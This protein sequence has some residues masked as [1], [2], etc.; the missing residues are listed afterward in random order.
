MRRAEALSSRELE[1]LEMIATGAKNAEIADRF[2]ISQNTVKSHVSQ[3][4]KKL[5]AANRTEAAFRY[6]ELY[7]APSASAGDAAR[8][9]RDVQRDAIRSARRAQ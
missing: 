6:I 5:S 9:Q 2:V 8:R 7:G 1:V 4:L 3:I